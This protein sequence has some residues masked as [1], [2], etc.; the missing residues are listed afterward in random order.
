MVSRLAEQNA[1][2]QRIEIAFFSKGLDSKDQSKDR[3]D[4]M[5]K[6]SE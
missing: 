6:A 1:M 5:Y 4:Q 3:E 2:N